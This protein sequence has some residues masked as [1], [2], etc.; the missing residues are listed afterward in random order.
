MA[1]MSQNQD[2]D[3][4]PAKTVPITT[5]LGS[6]VQSKP[7]L[8]AK[9]IPQ[10]TAATP[11]QI[12][13]SSESKR[14]EDETDS[15]LLSAKVLDY[16]PPWLFSLAFH[17]CMLIVMGLIVFA[18]NR[19]NKP[20]QLNVDTV[21]AEK[22]GNQL[23]FDSPLGVP[24][25]KTASEEPL[26]TPENLPPV[27][28]PFA[29]PSKL[30]MQPTGRQITS[31]IKAP[32]PGVAFSGR[33]E[34]SAKR[35]GLIGLYG[36]NATTEACVTKGLE[37]LARYQE[38]N[39]SW[40]LSG[41]Y[42]DGIRYKDM[43]NPTA[44]TA[45]ALLAFQGN[46]NTH[47]KGKFQKNVVNGWKWLLNQQ[48]D[49]GCFFKYGLNSHRFY[50]QGQCAIA[51]CELYGMTG[52]AKYKEPAQRAI[53]Y[54]LRTQ[55]PQGGWRYD[56][57]VDSDVSV[58]GWIMMA[59]QSARMAG[60][61]VPSENL[62]RVEKFLDEVAQNGGS[63]YPYQKGDEARLS[64]TAE[65]LLMRQYLGWKQDDP[66]LVEGV[67]WITSPENL[68]SFEKNRNVYYWYYATQVVHNMAGDPWE[69]W[70]KVMRQVLPEQQVPRGK[71]S[72]SWNPN[73]GG[74]KE[75]DQF[76]SHGGRLYVTC[77]S[78]YMLEVYYRH[79]PIYSNIYAPAG[80]TPKPEE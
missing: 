41:P 21:Y 69:R 43:D 79:L 55:S 23:M 59:M 20:I 52:D 37:W 36:G 60:L 11:P 3:G 65:A 9:S 51:L 44:A 68:I 34:G 54:C 22:L 53:G 8:Q 26:L 70:N 58:T 27:P 2:P 61:E 78:I 25:E 45:M 80:V 10:K 40:S 32:V 39:G 42:S 66:R 74:G 19:P 5:P 48:D 63:R 24:N 50:T 47:L 56:P 73:G 7:L 33:H 35:K 12:V 29:A 31:D 1:S 15:D 71:E 14:P 13:V 30:D 4:N 6:V 75:D 67:A 28:D 16:S 77:L 38:K 62:A 76:A 64:M 17:L 72:G 49:S 46:D 18:V 57:N